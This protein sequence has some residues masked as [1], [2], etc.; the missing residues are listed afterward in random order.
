M[1]HVEYLHIIVAVLLAF[2][3]STVYY[4]ILNKPYKR[5]VGVEA[6]AGGKYRMSM[7]PNRIIVELVRDFVLALVI[8]YAVTLLNLLYW[9]QA[10]LLAVWLWVGFPAVLLVGAV[11]HENYSR[12]LAAIHG[13]DWLL[14]LVIFSVVLTVWH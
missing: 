6:D 12:G 10:L 11:V 14:K 5:L 1:V 3:A 8:A 9:N 7:T 13:G 4:V 2:L